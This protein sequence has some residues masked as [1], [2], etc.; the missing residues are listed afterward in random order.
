MKISF[1]ATVL[2]EE[3]TINLLLNSIYSQTRKPDEIIIVDAKSKD[4]TVFEIKKFINFLTKRKSKIKIKIFLKKGNRSVGRN[5][6][7]EKA[8]GE[9]I[10]CSDAGC[11]LDKNWV[12]KIN[13]HF[14]NEQIDVVAGYYRGLPKS[15]FQEALVPYV[16]V[17]SD[18][19]NSKTFLPSS[20]SMGF[21]KSVWK[22]VG[23][24]PEKFSKNEDY[25]FANKLKNEKFKIIFSKSAVVYWIPRENI[26]D[27]FSMFFNFAE[28]DTES[29]I[30]RPKVT[31]LFIRYLIGFWILM[32]YFVLKLPFILNSIYVILILYIY[33]SIFKNYRYVKKIKAIFYLPLIQF[34]AD[35]AII[36]G[37]I[38][39]FKNLWV[40]QK[41]R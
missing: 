35:F 24:F 9:I 29:G 4:N 23:G 30:L 38:A 3:K 34:I 21:R 39:G 2:N 11:I 16:L 7:I 10:V 20:R 26:K 28:G 1:I 18:K 32:F 37:T 6:A 5:L 36:L 25:V 41:K 13:D 15:I 22:K 33:W 19:V 31:F 40:I 27:A 12:R 17:M 14:R 8:I